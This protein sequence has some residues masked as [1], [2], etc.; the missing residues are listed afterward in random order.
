MAW[1]A[2]LLSAGLNPL[3]SLAAVVRKVDSTI[4]WINDLPKVSAIGFRNT[5]PLDSDFSSG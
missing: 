5:Y 4:H 3:K 2:V 1:V